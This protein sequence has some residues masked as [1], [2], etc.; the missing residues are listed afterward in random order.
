MPRLGADAYRQVPT[1]NGPFRYACDR[2]E[3]REAR[4]WGVASV[5]GGDRGQR[6]Q[7]EVGLCDPCAA[8]VAAPGGMRSSMGGDTHTIAGNGRKG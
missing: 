6:R 1:E 7:I 8:S 4:R 3:S 2:C 5:G